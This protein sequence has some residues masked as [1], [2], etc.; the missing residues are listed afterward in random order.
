MILA[1]ITGWQVLTALGTLVVLAAAVGVAFAVLRSN[2]TRTTADLWHE[3][4]E[5]LRTRLDTVEKSEASCK[6]RLADLERKYEL[7]VELA[8]GRAAIET[9]TT[10]VLDKLNT[11][12]S[13]LDHAI[14]A[15]P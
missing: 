6:T 15:T 1:G 7:A 10:T 2:L 3:E 8:T 9:L 4:A 14:E 12:D 5:A 13:K 11:I